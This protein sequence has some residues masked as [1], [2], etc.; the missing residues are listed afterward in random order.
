MESSTKHAAIHVAGNACDNIHATSNRELIEMLVST[1]VLSAAVLSS[2]AV[3]VA[4]DGQ[5]FKQLQSSGPV[6]VNINVN[7]NGSNIDGKNV[8][9]S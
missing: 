9:A 3:A 8:M 6:N 1:F 2:V 7:L 5:L 4:D